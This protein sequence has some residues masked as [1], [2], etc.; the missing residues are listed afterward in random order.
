M[1]AVVT[2]QVGVGKKPYLEKVAA[3]ALDYGQRVTVC[4]IGAMMYREAPDVAPGRILDLPISRLNSL[5]RSVFKD[6]LATCERVGD[7]PNH[8]VLVN[9]HTT[10][11]WRHGLFYAF[12]LDQIQALEASLYVSLLDN[13]DRVYYRITR[14][15]RADPTLKDLMVWREEETLATELLSQIAKG[16]G[17]F[18]VMA[19]GEDDATADAMARLMC[20]PEATTAYLSYPMSHVHRTPELIGTIQGFRR[21]MTRLLTCFDPGDMEE[22]HI[23]SRALQAAEAGRHAVQVGPADAQVTLETGRVIEVIPDIDGQIY[24]R[25]FK[26]IDQADAIVALIPEMEAGHPALSSGVERELQHAHEAAK[27]V[28]VIWLPEAE[29][30][31]FITETA[32]RVFRSLQDAIEYFEGAVPAPP[33]AQE[34]LFGTPGN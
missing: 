5:R 25:D 33:S 14:D 17:H 18:Y 32:S 11:R 24:S 26:L 19:R 21:E 2:G 20:H 31:V 13:I 1:R 12:D 8:H 4:N 34:S 15:G 7:D 6:V 9:T 3:A 16:H 23:C 22:K 29:P 10:F 28:Y 30:S 27:D